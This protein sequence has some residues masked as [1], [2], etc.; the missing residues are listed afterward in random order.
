MNNKITGLVLSLASGIGAVAFAV[1]VAGASGGVGNF[2]SLPS[3]VF[4]VGVGYGF[5]Y[6]RTHILKDQEFGKVLRSNFILA[7]WLGFIVGIILVG[8]GSE[9]ISDMPAPGLSAAT[10]S[11]LYG[12]V[13]GAIAEVFLNK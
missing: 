1:L 6:M 12:Y 5:T 10:V 13:I 2:L 11:V 4:V 9:S 8:A 3:L 7:G